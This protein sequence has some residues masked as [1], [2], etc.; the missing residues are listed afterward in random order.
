VADR[1]RASVK[2]EERLARMLAVVPYLI[3]HPGTTLDEASDLFAIP[4]PQLRRDLEQLFLAG[5]PPYGPGDLIDVDIDEDGG[6]WIAMADQFA[7]PLRLTR[8]EA[9]GVYVRAT[10]LAATPGI[11]VAPALTA[12]L[13]KLRDALGPDSLGEAAGIA[14]AEPGTPPPSLDAVRAAS[15]SHDRIRIAYV[16]QSTGER[17]ERVVEPEAVF[18]S[19]GHWYAAVWDVE[20]DDERLLRVDRIATVEPTGERF[21]PRGLRG[22][23]RPLYTPTDRDVDVRVLLH[24]AARWVAEYYLA[25]DV[26]ERP[27][28]SVEVTLPTATTRWIARLLLRLGPDAEVLEPASVHDEIVAEAQESLAR[29]RPRPA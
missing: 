24:P 14:G 3:Q 26:T 10:E 1:P 7:R 22:A 25:R 13:A 9:L 27:D 11:P 16:A 28:G 2:V 19:A 8:Q 21:S 29:Y 20:V 12:A 18:A 17:T 5:L 6:I 23:G 4:V 15:A